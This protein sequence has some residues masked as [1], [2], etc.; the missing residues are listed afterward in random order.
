[1]TKS[2]FKEVCKHAI[3]NV[4]ETVPDGE[5][6]RVY[7]KKYPTGEYIVIECA[8]FKYTHQ[9]SGNELIEGPEGLDE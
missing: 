8:G 6:L 2:Y 3:S 7:H 5:N 4:L 9:S 1:M